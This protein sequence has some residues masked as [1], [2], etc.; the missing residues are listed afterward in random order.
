V[1][2]PLLIHKDLATLEA[3]APQNF[4]HEFEELGVVHRARKLE[5]PKVTGAVMVVLTAT[6]T[7]FSIFQHTHAGIKQAIQFAFSGRGIR[8]LTYRATHNFLRAE[9]PKLDPHNRLSFR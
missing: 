8:N 6:A 1:C 7:D 2:I 5:M 9:D 3:H 4:H